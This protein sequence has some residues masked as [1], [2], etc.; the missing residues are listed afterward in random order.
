MTMFDKLCVV[1]PTD[2]GAVVPLLHDFP[3]IS[4]RPCKQIYVIWQSGLR[5]KSRHLFVISATDIDSDVGKLF[6]EKIINQLVFAC[7]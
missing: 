1:F 7:C 5:Q 3:L 6:G 2:F 4:I